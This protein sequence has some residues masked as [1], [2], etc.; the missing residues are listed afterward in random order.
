MV[1][2]AY[3]VSHSTTTMMQEVIDDFII[4]EEYGKSWVYI[5]FNESEIFSQHKRAKR[6]PTRFIL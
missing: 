1:K 5:H 3:S 6:V 2:I 4:E